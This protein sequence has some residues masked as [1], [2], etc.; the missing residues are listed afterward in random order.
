VLPLHTQS[1]AVTPLLNW[2][3][4]QR[5]THQVLDDELLPMLNAMSQGRAGSMCT[6][7]ADSAH[8]VFRRMASYAVQSPQRLPLEATNLL[9]AG[10]VD[11]VVFID[12]QFDTQVAVGGP[13]QLRSAGVG[14]A[15]G[16]SGSGPVV[17]QR[18][19]STVLEVVDADGVHVVS[20]E[21]VRPSP[22]GPVFAAP[23][24]ERT[25]ADLVRVGYRPAVGAGASW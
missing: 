8:G 13:G 6:I 19:V 24:R 15:C 10:A 18:T 7:H 12:V 11:F 1:A 14:R 25:L 5:S 17:R 20:N 4:V 3:F 16:G 9:V 21:V 23:L 22:S 2:G